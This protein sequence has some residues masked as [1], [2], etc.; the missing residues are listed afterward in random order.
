MTIRALPVARAAML[1]SVTDH[2]SMNAAKLRIYT[3]AYTADDAAPTGTLLAEFS[4]GA[5]AF[6]APSD[7]A[8]KAT[9]ALNSVSPVT[10]LAT[11][12]AASFEIVNS[13]GPV[14]LLKGDV[15]ATGG[16][17]GVTLNN[18]AIVA[19]GNCQVT[20]GSLQMPGQ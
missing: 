18:T 17:G 4:L 15:T 11:G 13:T 20:G 19:G 1:Q 12:T 16:G 6:A 10:A 5:D 3:G 9:A 2:T 8:T 14:R 7:D